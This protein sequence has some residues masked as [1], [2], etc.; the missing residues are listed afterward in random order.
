MDAL[1]VSTHCFAPRV[2]KT[3][4]TTGEGDSHNKAGSRNCVIA[5]CTALCADPASEN[6]STKYGAFVRC[7]LNSAVAFASAD[8][9]A[10]LR[11]QQ[12]PHGFPVHRFR[13][14]KKLTPSLLLQSKQCLQN[15]VVC[16]AYFYFSQRNC[17]PD[18]HPIARFHVPHTA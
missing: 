18:Q 12:S 15:A 5:E 14:L 10:V 6:S 7:V 4:A 17:W 8:R 11:A 3:C 2:C 1:D 13:T 16:A 9:R